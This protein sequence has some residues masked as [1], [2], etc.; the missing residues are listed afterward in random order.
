MP[1]DHEKFVAMLGAEFPEVIAGFQPTEGG[2]L[3]CEMA[4]FRRSAE[5]AMDAGRLWAVE[6]CQ[7]DSTSSDRWCGA[8]GAG[9]DR[10]RRAA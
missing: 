2:I 9:Y 3:H 1:I 10:R 4:A 5:E 8:S 6:T 7:A